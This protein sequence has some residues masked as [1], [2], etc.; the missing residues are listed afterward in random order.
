MQ[1]TN[2]SSMSSGSTTSLFYRD[3]GARWQH[4]DS[5][6][7]PKTRKTFERGLEDL[8]GERPS[9]IIRSGKG[10]ECSVTQERTAS[11]FG[12][13]LVSHN[14]QHHH[15]SQRGDRSRD[16]DRSGR[17]P[18]ATGVGLRGATAAG[19]GPRARAERDR[20]CFAVR[21]RGRAGRALQVLI[22]SY[23]LAFEGGASRAHISFVQCVSQ[24]IPLASS[25]PVPRMDAAS[26]RENRDARNRNAVY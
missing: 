10:W 8:H 3:L 17:G 5:R 22:S 11:M 2:T 25:L 23:C 12:M 14:H 1:H 4:D 20:F 24:A 16:V 21:T 7:R 13:S 9:I 26:M 6:W 18:R 19:A 15:K